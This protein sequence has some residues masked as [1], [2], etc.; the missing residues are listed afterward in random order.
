MYL[1]DGERLLIFAS[2]GGGPTSPDWFHNLTTHPDVVIEV[3]NEI[4]EA[5]AYQITGEERDVL[6]AKQAELYPMFSDYALRTTRVIPV[7]GIERI[8]KV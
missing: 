6:Y 5:T 7:I 8:S 2:K 4:F 3:G 1:E